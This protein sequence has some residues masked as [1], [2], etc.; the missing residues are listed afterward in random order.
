MKFSISSK[1]LLRTLTT[2]SKVILKRN[3]LPLLD[4][5]LVSFRDDKF[6]ITGSSPE[7]TLMLPIDLRSMDKATFRPF[8]LPVAMLSPIL[9][10]LSEQ[11]VEI[12]IDDTTFLATFRYQGGDFSVPAYDGADFP[13]PKEQ[14]HTYVEFSMPTSV[15]IP[16][17]KAAS[18]C[19]ADDELRPVLNAVALDVSNEGVTFAAT[20]GTMLYKY[21]YSHGVPFVTKGEPRMILLHKKAISALDA[22]FSNSEEISLRHDGRKLIIEADGITF[23]V[24]DIEG[25]FPNYNSV[26]P[27]QSPYHIVMPVR[28]LINA[29][30][31]VAL[32]ANTSTQIVSV[33]KQDGAVSLRTED[34][35]FSRKANEALHS[36]DCT[37]P[38]G[39]AIGL[40]S[41]HFLEML[42]AISTD[43]VRLEL[44]AHDRPIIIRED[45]AN[46][47]LVELLMP[48]RLDA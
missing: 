1:E 48:M 20:S 24:T 37:L 35:D 13:L 21:V 38:D 19:T 23:V 31:R 43:N 12:S 6:F 26:I 2:V 29:V 42:S 27:T 8:C 33:R 44:T 46:S 7:S 45:A 10:T 14:E 4:N 16:A 32:M 15:F 34:T 47:S 22:A 28:D 3:T 40:R 25:K 11:P 5:A 41:T 30:K 39:F 9:A 17:V 36:D 18:V